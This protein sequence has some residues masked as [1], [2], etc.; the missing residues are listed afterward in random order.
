MLLC[1]VDGVKLDPRARL[2]LHC[3]VMTSRRTPPRTASCLA[4]GERE[5]ED[6]LQPSE[7]PAHPGHKTTRN[8][9]QQHNGGFRER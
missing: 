6:L 5:Q 2:C 7:Q 1:L 3:C 8:H 9:A 4:T